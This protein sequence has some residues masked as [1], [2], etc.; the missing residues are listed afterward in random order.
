MNAPRNL[1]ISTMTPT[2][3][4]RKDGSVEMIIGE[5]RGQLSGIKESIDRLERHFD[6]HADKVDEIGKRLDDMES[7]VKMGWRILVVLG[8]AAGV[9]GA[10]AKH[11]MDKLL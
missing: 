8:A 10:G 4:R 11:L 7:N 3:E 1:W 5:V 2:I 6:Q 9:G